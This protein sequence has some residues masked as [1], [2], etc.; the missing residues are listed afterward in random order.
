MFGQALIEERIV[1]IQQFDDASILAQ[2]V[3]EEQLGLPLE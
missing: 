1:R 3:F 2:D